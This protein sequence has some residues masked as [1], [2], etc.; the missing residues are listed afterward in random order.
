VA[1]GR[2]IVDRISNATLHVYESGHL[3]LV[4]DPT[5]WPEI[6]AFLGA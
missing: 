2:A 1:N 4:Q 3:F 6:A 5:A